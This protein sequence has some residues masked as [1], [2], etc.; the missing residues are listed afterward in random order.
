MPDRARLRHRGERAHMDLSGSTLMITG[1][2]GSFGSTILRHFRTRP[3]AEVRVGCG[4][5]TKQEDPRQRFR[6]C[7]LHLRSEVEPDADLGRL[8]PDE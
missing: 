7:R 2:T 8:D 5:E 3:V 4:D 6:H 1:G